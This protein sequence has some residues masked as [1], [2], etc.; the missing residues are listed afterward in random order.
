MSNC[1]PCSP[2]LS[3]LPARTDTN[4]ARTAERQRDKEVHKRH[5]AALCEACADIAHHI[6]NNLAEFNGRAGD[7][8][9]FDLLHELIQLQ[10]YRLAFWRVAADEINYRRFFDINDLAALRME[11]PAVF[12]V[13]HRFVLDLL[14]QGKV[15]GLR[16]DHPDGLYDPGQYFRRLQQAVAG[17]APAPGEPLPLYLVIEKI[18]ADHERLP[19]DWPIHGATGYRFA[20]LVNNLFVDSSAERRMTRVYRDF[21]GCDEDFDT[22]AYEA[23]KLIM[24]T[25]LASRVDRA[26][27]PPRAHRRGQPRHLRLHA[28]RPAR[29]TGGSGGLLPGLSQLRRPRPRVCR[30]P[31]SHRLGRGG[32]QKAQ[33]GRR[34]RHLTNFSKACSPPT[35]LAAAAPPFVSGYRPSPCAFSS[36]PRR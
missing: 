13:T 34:H 17:K 22:L 8:A 36:S 31:A 23:K 35:L 12:E 30:R 9:S 7:A 18:L 25:A 26:R 28:Q 19:D 6:A 29:R 24:H 10:G 5:L 11:D 16:I 33:P 2:R 14:A 3:H 21:T 4:P 1:K 32:G 27:H 15:D 20:N